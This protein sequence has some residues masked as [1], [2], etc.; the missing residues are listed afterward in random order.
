MRDMPALPTWVCGRTILIGDA[1]HPSAFHSKLFHA[2]DSL[3]SNH[4]YQ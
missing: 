1:A 3:T 4:V 2:S